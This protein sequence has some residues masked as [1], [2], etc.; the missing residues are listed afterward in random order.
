M[1]P[2]GRPRPSSRSPD[3]VTLASERF[4][5]TCTIA[6]SLTPWPDPSRAAIVRPAEAL[7]GWPAAAAVR[8]RA[9][10][11][12]AIRLVRG[13]P[14]GDRA[15]KYLRRTGWWGAREHPSGIGGTSPPSDRI[16]RHDTHAVPPDLSSCLRER[17]LV[18][19]IT[20]ELC[21]RA[22][23]PFSSDSSIA[24]AT[25]SLRDSAPLSATRRSMI[26]SSASVAR[27]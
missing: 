23:L 9:V 3:V 10:A 13:A 5:L 7:V 24:A 8:A 26:S 15:R 27:N 16:A 4:W 14:G 25:S 2:L 1:L 6:M 11:W 22:Q 17:Q 18:S 12:G 21:A 19:G 20:T